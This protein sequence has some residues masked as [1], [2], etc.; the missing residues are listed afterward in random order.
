MAHE[1]DVPGVDLASRLE[2]GDPGQD[3]AGEV[4]A[5]RSRGAPGRAADAAI[6]EAEHGD[7]AASQRVGK[8]QEWL[9]LEDRLV[10]VLGARAADQDHGRKRAG[11]FGLGQR[12]G[13]RHASGLVGVADIHHLVG[14]RSF[15]R[16]RPAQLGGL[17]RLL[18]VQ[19]KASSRLGPC[20]DGLGT[21]LHSACP[22]TCP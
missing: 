12:S 17:V 14:E 21:R 11:S 4:V 5:G 10:A 13:Q 20:A 1:S 15:G 9:V 7:P 2:E 3:V 6:I 16:L 19:G 18:H 8:D 22:R